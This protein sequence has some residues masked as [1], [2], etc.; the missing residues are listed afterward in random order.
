MLYTWL[1]VAQAKGELKQQGMDLSG[2]SDEEIMRIYTAGKAP[3]PVKKEED[4][5]ES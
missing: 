3:F 5:A 4:N 1:E 2:Y